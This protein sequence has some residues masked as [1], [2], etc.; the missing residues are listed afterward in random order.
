MY[1]RVGIP[2]S[3]ST[4]LCPPTATALQTRSVIT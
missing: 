4:C 3:E 2:I 1:Q